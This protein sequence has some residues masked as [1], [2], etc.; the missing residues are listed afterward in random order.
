[1]ATQYAYPFMKVSAL[2]ESWEDISNVSKDEFDNVSVV[3]E[4]EC[5]LESEWPNKARY[6]V[7]PNIASL[8]KNSFSPITKPEPIP[9]D[10]H[11]SWKEHCTKV[12]ELEEEKKQLAKKIIQAEDKITEAEKT[13]QN[14]SAARW[15]AK[16]ARDNLI[17][18]LQDDL[19]L[20]HEVIIDK[21]REIDTFKA[22]KK[23]LGEYLE[24]KAKTQEMYDEWVKEKHAGWK[25]VYGNLQ[26]IQD[27][28]M[29]PLFFH[30]AIQIRCG[31]DLNTFTFPD[32]HTT[33]MCMKQLE[34]GGYTKIRRDTWT[35]ITVFERR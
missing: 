25:K 7:L 26:P 30:G 17:S 20:A 2:E 24:M 5:A 9:E 28:V 4:E 11:K 34:L 6:N 18:R 10:F 21:I 19:R 1:M 33:E 3:F 35:T 15:G 29:I 8:V 23:H 16:S 14:Y 32:D 13:P 27:S 31:E 12:S 22:T